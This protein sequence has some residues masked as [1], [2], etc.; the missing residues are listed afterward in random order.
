M[1]PLGPSS[2]AA[3]ANVRLEDD[4]RAYLLALPFNAYQQPS[5][6]QVGD[7]L[8]QLTGT[9]VMTRPWVFCEDLGAW[10]NGATMVFP[11]PAT[12]GSGWGVVCDSN[13]FDSETS[14]VWT[15]VL[16]VGSRADRVLDNWMGTR[17]CAPTLPLL[18]LH[19]SDDLLQHE[20]EFLTL[21]DSLNYIPCVWMLAHVMS[22]LPADEA[23]S[24]RALVGLR[25]GAAAVARLWTLVEYAATLIENL[26]HVNEVKDVLRQ[27]VLRVSGQTVNAAQVEAMRLSEPLLQTPYCDWVAVATGLVEQAE[28]TEHAPRAVTTGQLLYPSIV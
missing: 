10:E 17:R 21:G 13:P 11:L 4:L 16:S 2:P 3:V 28:D 22:L 23:G 9:H 19:L 20:A 12:V 14:G 7:Y 8:A 15:G 5:E 6:V 26:A 18:A 1:P 25:H 24:T 27:A